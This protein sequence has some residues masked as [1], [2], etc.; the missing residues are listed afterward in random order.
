MR[1]HC[2]VMLVDGTQRRSSCIENSGP[3]DNSAKGTVAKE[4]VEASCG[5]DRYESCSAR[6][7]AAK[8][9]DVH[10]SAQQR[11]AYLALD[12]SDSLINLTYYA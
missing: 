10:R 3:P 7:T 6:E 12:D 1:R 2:A 8:K 5:G 11:P 9:S 4:R